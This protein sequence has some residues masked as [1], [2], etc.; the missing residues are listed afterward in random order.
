M[1]VWNTNNWKIWI[2]TNGNFFYT[3]LVKYAKYLSIK[4]LEKNKN[5]GRPK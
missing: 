5:Q 2:K 4:N 1:Q 3:N